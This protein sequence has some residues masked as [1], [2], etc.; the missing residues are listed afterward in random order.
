MLLTTAGLHPAQGLAH[1]WLS[2]ICDEQVEEEVNG[3]A[4][5]WGLFSCLSIK[6]LTWPC[7]S[8]SC[9]DRR[10]RPNEWPGGS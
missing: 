4:R 2:K 10:L 9:F 1:G 3:P 7:L 6:A 5:P 8:K